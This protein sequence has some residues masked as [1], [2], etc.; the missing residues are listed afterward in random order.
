MSQLSDKV[1]ELGIEINSIHLGL[2]MR[3]KV[4]EHWSHDKW[5]VT[6]K[7]NN[8]E[9]TTSYKTGLG[10]RALGI[11][12]K[13]EK[14]VISTPKGNYRNIEDIVTIPGYTKTV[15][16]KAADVLYSLFCDYSAN[17]LTFEQWCNEFGYD[18]DSRKML[19]I[20]IESQKNG[21][22]VCKLLGKDME[23]LRDLEH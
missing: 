11:C 20:Y 9:L 5:Q 15:E 10:H 8:K 16:P 23:T 17:E 6:I 19:D 21:T 14:G 3:D 13:Q 1:K 22:M 2:S 7:Y 18:S 4:K 12:C